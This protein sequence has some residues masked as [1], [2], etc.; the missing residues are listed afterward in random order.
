MTRKTE[1]LLRIASTVLGIALGLTVGSIVA[2]SSDEPKANVRGFMSGGFVPPTSSGGGGGGSGDI[3]AVTAGSG[4]AGGG[5]SGDVDLAIGAGSGITVTADAIS[6]SIGTGLTYSGN[7]IVTNLAGG[8]CAN[9]QG[10]VSVSAA[11]VATCSDVAPNAY[12]GTHFEWIDELVY[13]ATGGAI[14]FGNW[15]QTVTGTGA[16]G[17]HSTTAAIT[18]PGIWELS[19]G[20]TLTGRA[21]FAMAGGTAGSTSTFVDFGSG[22]WTGEITIGFPTLSTV[23]EEYSWF[24]GF[25]DV[26]TSANITDGCG[27]LYDRGNVLT[28]GGNAGNADKFQCF[29]QNNTSHTGSIFLMDGSTVSANS[30]T[31]VNAPVAAYTAPSTNIYTLKVACTGTTKCEFYVNNVKSCEIAANIP[32]GASR[33]TSF[34]GSMLLKSLG[35]TART[36]LIDR[37][38]VAVDLTSARSP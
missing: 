25:G 32:S 4:L 37:V 11:G 12:G 6:T 15:S 14:T 19:T 21:A 20:T 3:T 7:S 5:A 9:G 26:I 24:G 10:V 35:M 36:A 30:F 22:N 33:M 16:T 34:V 28:S 1:L 18:R 38:R 29:C 27:F 8:T 31:T 13:G 2:C 23:I 17:G